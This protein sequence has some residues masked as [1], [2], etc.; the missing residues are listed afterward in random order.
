MEGHGEN[1]T[2]SD[3]NTDSQTNSDTYLKKVIH[4]P[5]FEILSTSAFKKIPNL[6]SVVRLIFECDL[7]SV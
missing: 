3:E 4:I 7:D 1:Y 2:S 5:T 6:K